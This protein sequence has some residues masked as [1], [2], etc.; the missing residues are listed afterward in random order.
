MDDGD[1]IRISV[2]IE[3]TLNDR[4]G[5]MTLAREIVERT[6]DERFWEES[7]P[8]NV[9]E[10]LHEIAVAGVYEVIPFEGPLDLH[11]TEVGA[12]K[13]PVP[14]WLAKELARQDETEEEDE[15]LPPKA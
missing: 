9:E 15:E 5:L 2:T 11:S 1:F 4:E 8:T 7:Y 6:Y 13:A 12:E 14:E 10:A 3:V